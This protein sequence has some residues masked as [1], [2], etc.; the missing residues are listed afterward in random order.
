[1]L[2]CRCVPSVSRN[3]N[4]ASSCKLNFLTFPRR[5]H[6]VQLQMAG[7]FALPFGGRCCAELHCHLATVANLRSLPLLPF[8]EPRHLPTP[9][10]FARLHSASPH[11]A[12]QA[13]LPLSPL[14]S[15]LANESSYLGSLEGSN[16]SCNTLSTKMNSFKNL[17][18]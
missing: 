11:R 8:S 18:Q 7:V 17:R 1:M 15:E 12:Q 14:L 4:T 16:L 3:T 6:S 5:F 10:G 9:K 2:I 13:R